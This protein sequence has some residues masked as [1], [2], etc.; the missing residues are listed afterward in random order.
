MALIP[1]PAC[2]HTVSEQAFICPSCGHPIAAGGENKQ[3]A[4]RVL[5]GVA[6]T[7]LSTAALMQIIV[8]V[9]FCLCTAAVIITAII[10][11]G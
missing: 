1:C 8:G 11:N 2:A 10:V 4:I 7:Y 5:G 3:T 6:G 9:V